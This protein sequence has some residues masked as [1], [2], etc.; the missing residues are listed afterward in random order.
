MRTL[1]ASDWHLSSF[2]PSRAVGLAELFLTRA[3]TAGDRVILNGDIFEGLFQHVEE[4][5]AAHPATLS[6]IEE[7]MH[8]RQLVRTA[9]NHDPDAGSLTLILDQVG[10]G[11]IL[12]AHGH[13]VDPLHRSSIG[14]FGDAISRRIG[15][16][17]IVRGAAGL[18]ERTANRIVGGAM[19]QTFRTR[20]RAMVRRERC[21]LG[22]FGHI[23]RPYYAAGDTYA[24]AGHLTPERLEYL[25]LTNGAV[26]L[27]YV[28]SDESSDERALSEPSW[29]SSSGQATTW[30]DLE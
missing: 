10:I 28:T 5:Q 13:T 9:G 20:C 7:M 26:H 8:D 19:E 16:L 25:V 3:Q 23:H 24:N 30:K 4:A 2:S 6:M 21:T 22:V 17:A 1:I 11:R 18:A 27:E 12:V 29:P 15:H 14:R